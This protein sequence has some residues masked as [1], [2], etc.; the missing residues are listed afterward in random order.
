[1]KVV[2]DTNV[3]VSAFLFD[4]G[5][6]RIIELGVASNF[7]IYSSRY[8]IEELRDVLV[9]KLGATPRFGA[10]AAIR[11]SK[12][13]AVVGVSGSVPRGTTGIDAQDSPIVKTCLSSKAD[14][15]VTGDKK[16]LNLRLPGIVILKSAAFLQHLRSRGIR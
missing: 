6:E 2:L 11:V 14:F 16:L 13:A 9:G 12:L 10:L 1:M 8:I 3:Y 7:R 5:P 4:R 15:L